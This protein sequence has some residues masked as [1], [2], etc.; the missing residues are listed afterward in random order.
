MTEKKY[1]QVRRRKLIS[2]AHQV[3]LTVL[4]HSTMKRSICYIIMQE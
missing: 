2:S 4:Q 1:N 3:K